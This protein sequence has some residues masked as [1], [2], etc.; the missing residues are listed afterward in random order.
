MS[1]F[2]PFTPNTTATAGK[3]VNVATGTGTNSASV[4]VSITVPSPFVLL[5]NLGATNVFVRLSS[6]ASPTATQA[7]IP[8]VA[9][10][11]HLYAN[12]VIQGNLGVAVVGVTVSNT[13][14]YVCPG[15]GGVV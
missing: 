11:V 4:V 14:V 2:T 10:S 8:L 13:M 6:E 5:A 3:T 15:Q 9:N 12:P 7:D 1:A